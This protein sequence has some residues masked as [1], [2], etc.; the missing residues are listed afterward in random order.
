[1]ANII[2]I[3][4][5]NAKELNIYARLTEAQLKNNEG[6]F[7]AES[8]KVIKVALQKGLVPIS[9]LMEERQIDGIGK[10]L[11]DRCPDVPVYTAPREVLSQLTGFE[12]T[13]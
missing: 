11:I 13:R 3:E 7:V 12:L 4:D 9:F 8:V 5:I 6:L 2:K 1:M 10:E